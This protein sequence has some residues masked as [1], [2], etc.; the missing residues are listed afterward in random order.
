MELSIYADLDMKFSDFSNDFSVP[1]FDLFENSRNGNTYQSHKFRVPIQFIY[2][3]IDV[4]Q[5]FNV[6]LK[7]KPISIL[8]YV[9]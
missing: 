3:V 5:T 8:Y 9:M 6:Y 4:Y 1:N 2:E 7:F